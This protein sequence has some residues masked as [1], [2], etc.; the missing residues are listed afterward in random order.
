VT[1]GLHLPQ[2]IL[3]T[4]PDLVRGVEIAV[5]PQIPL[6]LTNDIIVTSTVAHQLFP[7][8]QHRVTVRRISLTTGLGNLLTAPFG[9]YL[10]CHGASGL[11]GH[12]RF[13][14]RTATAPLL[15]GAGFVALGVLHLQ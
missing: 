5:L 3:P 1:L 4:W 11:A 14:A 12:Y 7:K 15:I 2:P 6:T 13:G 9:G 8:E 10:M